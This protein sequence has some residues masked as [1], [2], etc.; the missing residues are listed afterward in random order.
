MGRRDT[1]DPML[2]LTLLTLLPAALPQAS[3]VQEPAQDGRPA[4]SAPAA[5]E[6]PTSALRVIFGQLD[7]LQ[8]PDGSWA[9]ELRAT[10]LVLLAL[11]GD[12][13]T[14]GQG[15]YREQMRKGLGW[16]LSQAGKD[17]DLGGGEAKTHALA[18]G[19]LADC[20]ALTPMP[21]LKR[22]LQ[23]ALGRLAQ[24]DVAGSPEALAWAGLAA[25]SARQGKIDVPGALASALDKGLARRPA[26]DGDLAG[27]YVA[28]GRW[29]GKQP[30]EEWRA[31]LEGLP[32]PHG[33]HGSFG[34]TDEQLALRFHAHFQ[35][36]GDG[37]NEWYRKLVP[38]A[39]HR[40]RVAV[41]KGA[42]ASGADL[43]SLA[44]MALG[45]ESPYRLARAGEER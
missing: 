43:E 36:T 45:F 19:A 21:K 3:P 15:P 37:G 1:M 9:G 34:L 35:S 17:G 23:R 28:Y 8:R 39:W 22:P 5:V 27:A 6:S 20:Y 16:L 2:S 29:F 40:T 24:M 13:Q 12:G 26:S 32:G 42:E 41:G 25:A 10:S 7:A 11:L 44:L 4:R 30:P 33:P 18:T 31:A 14:L 38:V